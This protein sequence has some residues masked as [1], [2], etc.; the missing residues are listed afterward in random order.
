MRNNN[1]DIDSK[2]RA[3]KKL[4]LKILDG[5]RSLIIDYGFLFNPDELAMLKDYSIKFDNFTLFQFF[6]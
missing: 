2:N 1:L 3:L 4:A 6:S 5:V